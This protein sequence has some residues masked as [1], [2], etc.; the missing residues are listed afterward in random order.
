MPAEPIQSVIEL[1]IPHLAPQTSKEKVTE[2]Q[3]QELGLL[4]DPD[5]CNSNRVNTETISLG[6]KSCIHTVKENSSMPQ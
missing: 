3:E 1:P 2:V 6:V 4:K 5:Y